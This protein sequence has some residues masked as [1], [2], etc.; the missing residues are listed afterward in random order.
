MEG[1]QD[2]LG[3]N[4]LLLDVGVPFS[5]GPNGLLV[6]AQAMN[7]IRLWATHFGHVTVCA[8]I[9]DPKVGVEE[10]TSVYADPAELLASGRVTL[11]GF[12]WGYHLMDNLRCR[13]EVRK[14]YE[15]LVAQHRYLCFT[16]LGSFGAWGSIGVDE[17]IRQ[18][19]P[20]AIWLDL[21]LHE[22]IKT[23][24]GA[25]KDSFR[26]KIKS[27][28]AKRATDRAVKHCSLG[29]FHGKTVYDAYA[30]FCRQSELVHD[31][32]ISPKDEIS[33]DRITERL[34]ARSKDGIFRVG[35]LGRAH[36]MKA[37]L[38]WIEAMAMVAKSLGPTHLQATWLGDGPLL[39]S[40]RGLIRELGLESVV[41]FRG[42]VADR[43]EILD[44][45]RSQD[46]FAF[47]HVTPESPRCLIEALIS[48]LPIVG[49]DSSY[50]R[51]L[52]EGRGGALLSAIG[53][54]VA[55]ASNLIGLAEEPVAL[56][57]LTWAA[58]ANRGIYNDEAVFSHRSE[59][60]KRYL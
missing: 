20:F 2:A 36:P 24:R 45:L 53:D 15:A 41:Q 27:V 22:W 32:H 9:L 54:P 50:A 17:A 60:I 3:A 46:V 56:E 21:V 43:G 52:V 1:E 23:D 44:F 59:L 48:G 18:G 28:L 30:P 34:A 4:G 6:E 7:G 33:D 11:E 38:Q 19:R 35:Y 8:P 13:A 40:A 31:I 37:P 12:P 57:R 49:Y 51:E 16:N 14:R 29:L 25:P 47:C 26:G 42:F 39:D 5:Q 55:L 58:A 10:A